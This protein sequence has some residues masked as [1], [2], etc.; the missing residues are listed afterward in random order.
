MA[1]AQQSDEENLSGSG[2]DVIDDSNSDQDSDEETDI[3]LFGKGPCKYYNNK[4]CKDAEKCSYLHM[5]R[6]VSMDFNRMRVLKKT[7]RV[8]RL[9]DGKTVW[10]WYCTLRRK[11]TKYGDKDSKGKPGPAKSDDIENQFQLDPAGSYKFTAGAETFEIKF[12]EMRQVAATRKRK[13]TRRPLYRPKV[14][15]V[16]FGLQNLSL[17]DKPKWQFEGDSGAWHDFRRSDETPTGCSAGSEE[18]ERKYAQNPSDGMAIKVKGTA[19]KLDFQAMTQ[20]NLKT[21][22]ARKIRRV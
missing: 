2:S 8:R 13:V 9:D 16:A 14:S 12:R 18:I 15:S 5:C 20:L 10:V 1:T 19:Y 7:L 22:K 4:G 21:K 3:Q 17:N 6:A 11:W